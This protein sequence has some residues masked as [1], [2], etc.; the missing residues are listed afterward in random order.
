MSLDYRSIISLVSSAAK[1]DRTRV[2]ERTQARPEVRSG[3]AS[4]GPHS[5]L[6]DLHLSH[7][8]PSLR[9]I[10]CEYVDDPYIA[11]N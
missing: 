4:C 8:S 9:V 3:R 6:W 1:V 10:P 2:S 5:R 7:L 11:K